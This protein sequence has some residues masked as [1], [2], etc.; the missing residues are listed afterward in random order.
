MKIAIL[1][2]NE[3]FPD[4]S[5]VQAYVF[6]VENEVI[7]SVSDEL[8]SLRN[9]Q[10][11]MCWLLSKNIQQIFMKKPDRKLIK[12]LTDKDI[13]VRLLNE[14]KDNPLLGSFLMKKK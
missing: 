5:I 13:V 11:L 9:M 3:N 12:Y 4:E 10:Y 7:T 6:N 2:E 1:L 8:L 14:I